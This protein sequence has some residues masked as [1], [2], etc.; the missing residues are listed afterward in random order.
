MDPSLKF[1]CDEILRRL[2]ELDA[3]M[4]QRFSRT[5]ATL[6]QRGATVE[7]RVGGLEQAAATQLVEADNWGGLFDETPVPNTTYS[8]SDALPFTPAP[9]AASELPRPASE[10]FVSIALE[11]AC[12]FPAVDAL[13]ELESLGIN[14][15]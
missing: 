13:Q 9:E 15:S 12:V 4:E 5:M 10:Q 11:S 2:D 8:S 14:G 6:E 3:R 7:L 1:A